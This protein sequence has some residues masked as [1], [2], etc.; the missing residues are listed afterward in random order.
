ML[1]CPVMLLLSRLAYP[2]RARGGNERCGGGFEGGGGGSGRSGRGWP[3][4]SG[5]RSGESGSGRTAT[6]ARQRR[7]KNASSRRAGQDNKKTKEELD[8]ARGMVTLKSRVRRHMRN[9]VTG[10]GAEP[11]T[12]R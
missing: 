12:F 11:E 10:T 2:S 6:K 1:L 5:G 4:G 8:A 3:E 9:C 7:A